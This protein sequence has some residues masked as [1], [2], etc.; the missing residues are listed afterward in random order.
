MAVFTAPISFMM[1]NLGGESGMVLAAPTDL[2]MFSPVQAVIFADA[3]LIDSAA[4]SDTAA[5]STFICF[6][7]DCSMM[8][9]QNFKSGE[10]E[11][12]RERRIAVRKLAALTYC[13]NCKPFLS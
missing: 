13:S 3:G 4:A 11:K 5:S 9:L 12:F 10:I 1:A 2:A 6:L 7:P 8:L